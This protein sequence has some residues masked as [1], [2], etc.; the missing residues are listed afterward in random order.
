MKL[1]DLLFSFLKNI[2]NKSM[3]YYYIIYFQ[4][5]RNQVLK[6]GKLVL[7]SYGGLPLIFKGCIG[8]IFL[9][10]QDIEILKAPET[11]NILVRSSPS[12]P[13]HS[14]LSSTEITGNV[15]L[16]KL[17]LQKRRLQQFATS[18]RIVMSKVGLG[19]AKKQDQDRMNKNKTNTKTDYVR[20]RLNTQDS[21]RNS[22]SQ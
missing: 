18:L 3:Q 6:L 10:V 17:C 14:K 13:K 9:F 11:V 16:R 12:I 21:N 19:L 15:K 7:H 1:N 2:F 22:F 20:P 5:Y 8:L 4:L